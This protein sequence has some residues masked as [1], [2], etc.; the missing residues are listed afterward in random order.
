MKRMS[1]EE[2]PT[3]RHV[4]GSRSVVVRSLK[5]LLLLTWAM[6]S[7]HAQVLDP[8][9]LGGNGNWSN[10]TLWNIVAL[11]GTGS[12]VAIDG[13]NVLASAVTLD[14]NATV[15]R[16]DIS[17]G[18][19]L[20]IANN[21]NLTLA[22]ATGGIANQ[23]TLALGSVGN[24]TQIILSSGGTFTF[25]GTGV[26]TLSNNTA[27]RIYGS[28]NTETLINA[29]GHTIQG[30]GQLGLG[31]L[32]ISNAGLIQANQAAGLAIDPNASG[33]TNSGTLRATN[34]ATLTLQNGTFTNSSA[35][36]VV[37]AQNTS[38]VDLT[39]AT[40]NGGTL[41]S[42]GTG[43][44]QLFGDTT[45]SNLAISAGS[46]LELPNNQRANLTGSIQNAGTFKL[47]S[48]GNATDLV[49]TG[50]SATLSGG[51]TIMLSTNG[52]NRIYGTTGATVLINE[53]NT[54]TGAGQIGVNQLTLD[55][56]GTITASHAGATLTIDPAATGAKNTGTV[57]AVD[58]G[59]LRLQGGTFDNTSGTVLAQANSR[60]QIDSGTVT[61]GTVTIAGTGSLELTSSTVTGSA[62][63][64]ASGGIVKTTSGASTLGGNVTSAA[65]GQ[66]QVA[67]NTSLRLEATGTFNN[68]GTISL[69]SVGNLS[70]LIVA[71]G[72]VTLAGTGSLTLSNN[73]NN[74][75]YGAAATDRL[76]NDTGHTLQ[77]S[78]QLGVGLMGF[79]NL[80]TVVANQSTAL[81][82]DP[83]AAGAT[84]SGTLRAANNATLEITNGT[85]TNTGGTIEALTGS[86]VR[87]ESAIVTGGSLASA[88]TGHLVNALASTF[89]DVTLTTGSI[90]DI[91]N[92]TAA[93][94]GG[95]FT[96]RGI[97]QLNSVGN[98]TDVVVASG[99]LTLNGG[100]TLVL[101]N[102]G[103]NRIYGATGTT[104]LVNLDNVIRGTGQLGANQLQLD[105]R[106]LIEAN[107]AG[108]TL[109]LNPSGTGVVNTGTMQAVNG[110]TLTLTSGDFNNTGG[111]IR[112]QAG[113]A[114]HLQSAT[115][116]GGTF[117]VGPTGSV[118]LDTSTIN[119]GTFSGATTGTISTAGGANTVGGAVTINSGTQLNIGNNTNLKLLASG[120][121][122]HHG[123][124]SL[125][126]VGNFSDLLVSGGA[127]SVDGTGII[128]LGNHGNNRV[129]GLATG[130]RLVLG[131]TLTLR[132]GGQV[133]VGLMGLTNHGLI[134]ATFPA[135][136]LTLNPNSTGV[137]N[138]GTLRAASGATLRVTGGD[139][140]NTGGT[141]S[142]L[143][144]SRV[145]F[146]NVTLT[147]GTL[148]TAG[149]GRL[150]NVAAST[151]SG[152]TLSPGSVLDLS[153]NASATFLGTFSNQG[154]VNF[155]SVGN[156]VDFIAGT[157]G[158]TLQGG[159]TLALGNNS[160]N[161]IY[162]VTGTTTLI[163]QNNT[164]RGVGQ[165]GVNQ[166][167]L[168][169]R[170]TIAADTLNGT[171]EIDTAGS[172]AVNPNTGTLQA[173][174]GGIL[175]LQ[176]SAI[177]NAGGTIRA[178]AAS[179]VELANTTVT[180]GSLTTSGNGVIR[181]VSGASTLGGALLI[182]SGAQVTIENNTSLTLLASGAYTNQGVLALNSVG[183]L[184]DLRISGGD[185]VLSGGGTLALGN[186]GN[187]RIYGSGGADRLVNAGSTIRGSGQIGVGLLGLVNQGTVVAD[188]TVAL[189]IDPSAAGV[190]NT[191]RL[192]AAAGSTLRLSNGTFTNTNGTI[193]AIGAGAVVEFNSAIITNGTLASDA[194]AFLRNV[195]SSR[196]N[197]VTLAPGS[198]L[199][200]LNATQAHVSGT[201]INQATLALT[202]AGNF[203]DLIF[204]GNVTL[205]GGGTL[206]LGNNV[207][208]RLYSDTTNARLTNLN[209]TIQGSGQ[210][211][212]GLMGLVNQATI[213]A[214][215]PNALVIDPS[216]AGVTNTGLLRADSGATLRLQSGTI[217]NAGGTIEAF[218]AGS[219]V[220]FHTAT[221]SSGLLRSSDG[222]LLRNVSAST[223]ADISLS[224]GATLQI[225]NNTNATFTGTLTSSGVVQVL[226]VGNFADF[227][228]GTGGVTLAGGTLQLSDNV[229][230]RVY[231]PS[232]ATL[233]NQS[234]TIRGAGQV[235]VGLT[236][237][238]NRSVIDANLPG[239]TLTLD[240]NSGGATNTGLL[241]ATN[242]GI[243]RLKGGT[244][245]NT[246]GSIIA[247]AGSRVDLDA[248]TITGGVIGGSTIRN[249]VN[250]SLSAL[251]IGSGATVEISN[252]TLLTL[253]GAI[254]NSGTIRLQSAG[255]F[256]DLFIGSG[257]VTLSGP[258][259]LELSNN[260][261][262]RI[263]AAS[264]TTVLNNANHT[265]RGSGQLGIGQLSLT[266]TGTIE[267]NQSTALTV[268]VST[269]APFTNQG[270][271]RAT[272][273]ATL[274]FSAGLTNASEIAID[275][276][277]TFSTAG[278]LTQTSGSTS[279]QAGALSAASFALQAGTLQGNGT[280][281]GAVTSGG[282]IAPGAAGSAA[283]I[284]TL[285][286]NQTLTLSPTSLLHFEI[287]GIALTDRITA[288]SAFLNGALAVTFT[289]GF[290]FGVQTTDTF[291]LLSTVNP[292][293][294]TGSFAGLG[295]GARFLT[296]DGHGSFQINY[297]GNALMLSNFMAVPEPSTYALL[298]LG[299]VVIFFVQRR[300]RS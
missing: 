150:A 141:I 117:D 75:I 175:L 154:T 34:G 43:K 253:N 157:G 60:V 64:I 212:V 42:V 136:A 99:G 1:I 247:G 103:N 171:L 194:G 211:G 254:S 15:S 290:Q 219:L 133:G 14:V 104:T 191:G 231:S 106:S 115:V 121:Y 62:M 243:L 138:T 286:F 111:T 272:N 53:N 3:D 28:T 284:G 232:G 295:N 49:I 200:V 252:A 184:T 195:A 182:A 188:Q 265:I 266:N 87:F 11:P 156:L 257:G 164:I 17:S 88:G 32:A 86:T 148:T 293:G 261:N 173:V 77:G 152:V 294:L 204:S 297:S 58:G 81:V 137:T 283:G 65:G 225:L 126:S 277:S 97:V 33:F 123:T 259:V 57:Q 12:R 229:N 82:L 26:M 35:T 160:N 30:A 279:L 239:S 274:A 145:Q 73:G 273:A 167:Q 93:T 202:S 209:N 147:G 96:N 71:G 68:H 41:A 215:Q 179:R 255:N 25:S 203:T 146:E 134:E 19:T 251:S 267:A 151:Y 100:G 16:L 84:N 18:D 206:A 2:N 197:D 271:L 120:T 177:N 5:K 70:D 114:V 142:A 172:T 242:G 246:G 44:F 224:S 8:A 228:V 6:T 210:I 227:L 45:L 132:G 83:S 296:S 196:F 180:G 66:I 80:G 263:Y 221:V 149:S 235:G 37:E 127:V 192:R 31:L 193:E 241:T 69:N 216:A 176:N 153:N 244:Y 9:W 144:T 278:A 238:D 140:T 245:T 183:N 116:T 165:L 166:L 95:T 36:A 51:G 131:S 248:A 63:T 91:N 61:S 205:D 10:A 268:N 288:P 201:F 21:L 20:S 174:N 299:A 168:D 207:N 237:L 90:F 270:I 79:S 139:Y 298:G 181:T 47:L 94:F 118:T 72:N 217:N 74:R 220:D 40:I 92:A 135:T 52:N 234:A 240:P 169:N 300:R 236:R 101:S 48:V 275:A 287:G 7:L 102:N 249:A 109:T 187:N 292:G 38:K 161:R 112:A 222:G 46:N 98:L 258:G 23:G 27:N 281:S 143:D 269:A 264:G 59:I 289:N 233:I 213:K 85:L 39:A 260:P 230:N 280:I 128:S 256:T 162:G 110:G 218:G 214:N 78:G 29:A 155:N 54:I 122:A 250:S 198:T 24:L 276:G 282:K 208:N 170:G 113:S 119:G 226:S 199:Q 186:N 76:I 125:N 178:D 262:N 189:S 56:R 105:N 285:T 13:G 124:I 108:G 55:N 223:F 89:T 159:G 185:V 129:Y 4:A 291:T 130:D 67:N 158:V 107:L 163:N 22:G 190:T 50:T